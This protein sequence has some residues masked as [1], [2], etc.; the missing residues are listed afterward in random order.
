MTSHMNMPQQCLYHDAS[1][2]QGVELKFHQIMY[3]LVVVMALLLATVQFT[4]AFRHI[5]SSKS[6]CSGTTLK[7]AGFGK[8]AQSV[9][10]EV[11]VDGDTKCA[12]GS[13]A[14]YS[15][16]CGK[17]HPEGSVNADTPEALVR[18]RFSAFVYMKIGYLL[19]STHPE[20]KD[21]CLEEEV[22]GSKRT[23]RQ[24]WKKQLEARA[25][26]LDFS[27][28][29]FG[30]GGEELS[31][32]GDVATLKLTLDRKPKASMKW[33]K[34]AETITCKKGEDGGWMY[35]AGRTEVTEENNPKPKQVKITNKKR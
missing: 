13:D 32:T 15:E 34:C 6:L 19:Q 29:S 17:F 20:S 27:S 24:I 21:Y 5:A 14:K 12:C 23:R 11:A 33:D 1:F 2:I 22:V 3:P 35:L 30:E 31:A 28:L 25:G 26:E 4:D 10:K 9:S 18:A 7:M 16:C 8:Q